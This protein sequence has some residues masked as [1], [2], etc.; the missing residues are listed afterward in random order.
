MT[1]ITATI[2]M[3]ATPIPSKLKGYCKTSNIFDNEEKVIVKL[4]PIF[5]QPLFLE[6]K[7]ADISLSRKGKDSVTYTGEYIT[8]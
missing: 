4:S 8:C 7:L 5:P 2:R 6:I 1:E 3:D